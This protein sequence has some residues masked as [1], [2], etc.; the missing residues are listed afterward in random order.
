MK[1]KKKEKK[2]KKTIESYHK[3]NQTK[4]IEYVK[5]RKPFLLFRFKREFF[6]F[7]H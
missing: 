4:I 3:N 6:F 2:K 1:Q 7:E 5:R